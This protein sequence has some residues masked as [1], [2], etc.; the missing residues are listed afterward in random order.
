[1]KINSNGEFGFSRLAF[2]LL[3]LLVVL[4][5]IG[6]LAS[7]L[8]PALAAAKS[9]AQLVQCVNNLRQQGIGLQEFVNDHR[10]YPLV[11]SLNS[12]DAIGLSAVAQELDLKTMDKSHRIPGAAFGWAGIFRCPAA[13][14]W[15]VPLPGT[16]GQTHNAHYGYN[17]DGLVRLGSQ[18][19]TDI[20]SLGLGGHFVVG[21]GANHSTAPP[22]NQSDVA[23]PSEML[24]IGDSF[25]GS[26]GIILDASAV[27][28]RNKA[29]ADQPYLNYQQI[30]RLVYARHRSRANMVFCDGH[31]NTLT[32]KSL[33]DD[34]NDD[35]L[36]QWNRDHRPHR[37]QLVP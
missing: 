30:T 31:V 34:T 22:V 37:E 24:A 12:A 14:D 28:S 23:N 13:V 1:M 27:I 11:F 17:A 9:R 10:N 36:A 21:Q 2:T 35:A 20:S 32:F 26:K 29:W 5:V 3:E 4:A 16:S 19:A 15:S 25:S 18:G 7:L 6:I 33:F 8:L